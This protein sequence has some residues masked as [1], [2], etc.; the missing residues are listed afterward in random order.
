MS[1]TTAGVAA[2]AALAFAALIFGFWGF[3][4]VALFMAIGAVVGRTAEGKL[5]LGSVLDALRGR[6]SSS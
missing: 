3:V 4:L 1:P 5:D 2:G 6:R